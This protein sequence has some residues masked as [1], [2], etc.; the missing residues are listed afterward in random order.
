[1]IS[2]TNCR[3]KFTFT[4]GLISEIL[5]PA[6]GSGIKFLVFCDLKCVFLFYGF[7][8]QCFDFLREDPLG[9]RLILKV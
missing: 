6:I 8:S 7:S 1:M 3:K 4:L 9:S 5:K 2:F